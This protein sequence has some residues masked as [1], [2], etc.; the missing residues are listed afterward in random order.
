MANNTRSNFEVVVVGAGPAGL[1]AAVAASSAGARVAILD[2]NPAVGGQ[3]WRG[4]ASDW[5][6]RL[7]KAQVQIFCGAQVVHHDIKSQKLFAETNE[8]LLE[9]GFS[10]L[11]LA[12]GARE[13]FLPF[14]GWTVPNVM[15]AGGLQAL[16]KSGLPIARKR[17]VVLGSGP[18]LLAVAAYL[19]KHGAEVLAICEQASW[20]ALAGFA[21]GL[22]GEPGK[23]RQAFTLRRE[24]SG[25]P[26]WPNTWPLR[27]L[28]K[29]SLQAVILSG[30]GK[31]RE[32]ACDYLACGFH[33]VPNTEL[34][35]LLGCQLQSGY[36]QVDELQRTSIPGVFCVGE[37]TGI[38]GL[39]I[40][41]L[42]GE[43][44][45]REA[46]GRGDETPKLRRKLRRSQRFAAR[47][48]RAFALRPELKSLPEGDT[49]V[50]R[51]EDVTHARAGRHSS[52]RDAKNQT[53]CGMGP[54][55]GRVCGPATQFLYGWRAESIRPPLYPVRVQT[56]A[57]VHQ[58]TGGF[59]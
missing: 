1:S 5:S 37:P 16:V 11:I 58:T 27:A 38:G 36:V 25:I 21:F 55:Q 2:D 18:L 56:L 34:A 26:F 40:A 23:V 51:C 49:I 46:T 44:A 12:T 4:E 31:Q 35:T 28:G 15:A 19:R 42:E 6:D 47:M 41:L 24:I 48:E 13:R 57:A 14:P 30:N 59:Q 54:C 22:M 20:R 45:G 32:I 29:E 50:C 7:L 8:G 10:K 9:I 53:R 17:V 3:I 43:I 52:W 33:L 39:D